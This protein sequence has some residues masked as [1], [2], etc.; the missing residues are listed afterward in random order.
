LPVVVFGQNHL[1]VYDKTQVNSDEDVV[2]YINQTY[3]SVNKIME[4]IDYLN[5][6]HDCVGILIQLP[7]PAAFEPYKEKLVAA[8][9][10][11]KDVDGM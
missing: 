9:T 1:P 2:I 6:D 5:Y 7:L 11:E 8:I 4:L 3:D 10:P